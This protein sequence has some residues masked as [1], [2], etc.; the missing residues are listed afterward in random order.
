MYPN[1]FPQYPSEGLTDQ[2][3][4]NQQVMWNNGQYGY[5][6]NSFKNT[7]QYATSHNQDWSQYEPAHEFQRPQLPPQPQTV[8]N[9]PDNIRVTLQD[10]KEWKELH[11]LGNEMLVLSVGRMLSPQLNYLVT[12]LN[13]HE[14]YSFGL[15]LKRLNTNILKRVEGGWEE[16]KIKV[17]ASWES[18]EIFLD[19]KEGFVWME[20][21]VSFERAKIYSE[22]KRTRIVT[23][24]EEKRQEGL[25]INTRCRYIPVLSIYSQ[26]SEI[27]REFLKS[28]EI[29]KTQFVAVTCVKNT[30]VVNWK[31]AKNKFARVDYKKNLNRKR[32][33]LV[34]GSKESENDS[35]ILSANN[36]MASSRD[37]KIVAKRRQED[38]ECYQATVSTMG[39]PQ[40]NGNSNLELLLTRGPSTS[41]VAHYTPNFSNYNVTPGVPTFAFSTEKLSNGAPQYSMNDFRPLDQAS[42]ATN[43]LL[44]SL[45]SQPIPCRTVHHNMEQAGHQG[46]TRPTGPSNKSSWDNNNVTLDFSQ[47]SNY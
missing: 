46:I 47:N 6:H 36:T 18:N 1:P 43:N 3:R 17:K 8:L 25:L 7:H 42:M 21:E 23:E 40:S 4:M 37:S 19:T 5:P 28:F 15:K 27:A 44:I 39:V 22:K 32:S 13:T 12:G 9:N 16:S 26:K 20:D 31:T 14:N 24:T 29:E 45:Q 11:E 38:S 2:M 30:A 41:T 10:E 34:F 33:S 35:G